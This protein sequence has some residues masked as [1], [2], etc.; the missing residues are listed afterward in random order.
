MIGDGGGTQNTNAFS[1]LQRGVTTLVLLT[2]SSVPLQ[3]STHWDPATDVLTG[4]H[5]DFTLPAMF[6]VIATNLSVI[7]I[8]SFDLG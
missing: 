5:I 4:D 3:N 7:S 2:S 6:G 1:L 8:A